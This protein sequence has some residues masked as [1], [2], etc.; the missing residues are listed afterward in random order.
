MVIM[1]KRIV[2]KTGTQN[3]QTHKNPTSPVVILTLED[4]DV[5]TARGAI[6]MNFDNIF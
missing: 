4:G 3:T 2:P 6:D 1:T 5:K